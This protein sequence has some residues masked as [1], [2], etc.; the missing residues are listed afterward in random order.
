MCA[1]GSSAASPAIA[2]TGPGKA[3]VGDRGDA[4]G[5][6]RI[7]LNPRPPTVSSRLERRNPRHGPDP[8]FP[9]I[10]SRGFPR[11]QS[12]ESPLEGAGRFRGDRGSFLPRLIPTRART[13]LVPS[14]RGLPKSLRL[15]FADGSALAAEHVR[16]A[17]RDLGGEDRAG[18]GRASG[19][20]GLGPAGLRAAFRPS[21]TLAR[22]AGRPAVEGCGV[23]HT[24]KTRG[25]NG[26]GTGGVHA[27]NL[28]VRNGGT[29][30]QLGSC[31]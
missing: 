4:A 19:N 2:S 6:P 30:P 25:I 28:T 16:A 14:L 27:S 15:M 17:W 23:V 11:P 9:L 8:R 7:S 21:R 20:G 13:P 18:V 3:R 24:R 12:H 29:A 10:L 22:G 26:W 1:I 31:R 5:N